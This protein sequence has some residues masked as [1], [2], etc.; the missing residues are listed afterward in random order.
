MR[1]EREENANLSPDSRAGEGEGINAGLKKRA[2]NDASRT[3]N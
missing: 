3:T 1:V 2:T